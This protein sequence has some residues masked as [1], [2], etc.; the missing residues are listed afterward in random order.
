MKVFVC[1]INLCSLVYINIEIENLASIYLCKSVHSLK[2]ERE[3]SLALLPSDLV[4]TSEVYLTCQVLTKS[5]L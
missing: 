1:F 4:L 3:S 5:C 2:R